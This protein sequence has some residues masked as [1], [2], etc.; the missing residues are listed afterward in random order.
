VLGVE[1]DDEQPDEQEL[2]DDE[3]GA[4]AGEP[5]DPSISEDLEDPPVAVDRALGRG[6][7][8]STSPAASAPAREITASPK[9][10]ALLPAVA[11]RSGSTAA[12]TAAPTGSDA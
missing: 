11:A 4:G 6:G 12:A 1:V 2:T 9:S 5:P 8:R 3:Q 7:S 10:A